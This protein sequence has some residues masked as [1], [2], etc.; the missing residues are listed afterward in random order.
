MITVRLPEPLRNGRADVITMSATS[1]AD[2]IA[3]LGIEED[4]DEL[5]NFAINGELII[6]GEK[7]VKLDDGDEVEIVVAFS[8]G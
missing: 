1:L 5:Y 7:K 2:V 4:R 6:H 8:G 3:K